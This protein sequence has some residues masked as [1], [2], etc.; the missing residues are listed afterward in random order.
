MKFTLSWLKEYL[1]TNSTLDEISNKLTSIGLEVEDITDFSKILKPFQVAEILEATQHPNADK[2]RVCKV[3]AG[4][5]KILQIVCGA[6]NARAGIKV[7]LANIGVNIPNGNFEIKKSKIRGVES[8]GMLCSASEL[9]ISEDSEGIIELPQNSLVGDESA[10]YMGLDD[11]VIEI[12]ITPNRGDCLGVYGIARDLSATGIGTL[13][14]LEIKDYSG[15]F[16]SSITQNILDEACKYFVGVYIK[17]IQNHK[18]PEWLV[19]KLES[20]GK[21]SISAAVDI[22]NYLTF[23]FNRPAHVY[24][25]DKLKG[26]LQIRR[27]KTGEKILALDDKEYNLN[28]NILVIADGEKPQAIAGVIGGKES[29]VTENTKN[30]YLEI[31][32]FDADIV[33]KNGRDLNIIT[34]SRY[35]FERTIDFNSHQFHKLA[36]N[37]ITENCGGEASKPEIS[38]DLNF[39]NTEIDFDFNLISKRTAINIEKSEALRILQK[40]DFVISGNKLKV[41]SHRPDISIPEDITEEIARIKGFENIPVIR[42]DKNNVVKIKPT[43]FEK[44]ISNIQ[45]LLIATGLDELVTFSF[46]NEKRALNFVKNEAELIK[47]QNPI[48]LELGVMRPNLLTNL[49]LAVNENISRGKKN[50]NFFEIGNVFVNKENFKDTKEFEKQ[51]I[52]IL[53]TGKISEKTALNKEVENDFYSIK[54]S[55]ELAID[56]FI[57]SEKLRIENNSQFSYYHPAKSAVYLLGNKIVAVCGEIHPEILKIF[58]IKQKTFAGEIFIENLPQPKA[59]PI[60]KKPLE[61]YNFQQVE[62]DFAFVLDNKI[63]SAEIINLVKKAEK[64]ILEEV[65]IFDVYQDE[66]L[67][68]ENKKSVAFKIKLQPKLQTL[69]DEQINKISDNIIFAITNIGGVLRAV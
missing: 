13:K 7:V 20:I 8:E 26:N 3:D 68:A 16:Q 47:V 69:T 61:I 14:P 1:E 24:D 55:L 17:N 38:G 53:K 51:N 12:A 67:K 54:A 9:N 11:A 65:T 66:K 37:L 29:S 35:R 19:K 36:V 32:N 45:K 50:L 42:L 5:G 31:A 59:K 58:D 43:E 46:L 18:S 33:T 27:A 21:K 62:R 15:N 63:T 4:N 23:A 64:E 44:T 6:P 40:L 39:K 10:K 34:D 25:A 30:I 49:L 28:E 52:A 56:N 41:P 2:L 60:S 22:T 48:S 57:D